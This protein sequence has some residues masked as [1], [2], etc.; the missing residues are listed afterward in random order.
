MPVRALGRHLL[1][2]HSKNCSHNPYPALN[3]MSK[4]LQTLQFPVK[5]TVWRVLSWSQKCKCERS[6]L[7]T[8]GSTF[9]TCSTMPDLKLF[10]LMWIW[11]IS[12]HKQNMHKS[13]SHHTVS[14]GFEFGWLARSTPVCVHEVVCR[15][16]AGVPTII[17]WPQ[18]NL[19]FF[20]VIQAGLVAPMSKITIRG[21]H[22][23]A[24]RRLSD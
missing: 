15:D 6:V 22:K 11:K 21:Q 14:K 16:T 24:L 10:I 2:E 17:A 7:T 18:T 8:A 3:L 23:Q 13:F 9:N 5:V 20:H 19:S 4:Q 1:D 12:F